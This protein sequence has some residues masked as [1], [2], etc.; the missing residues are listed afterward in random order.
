MNFSSS[1]N[2][3]THKKQI[4]RNV[5]PY[6]CGECSK[7]FY[8]ASALQSHQ[9]VHTEN[10]P[11]TCVQCNQ[12][13]KCEQSLNQHQRTHTGEK[14]YLCEECNTGF[15]VPASL[16]RHKESFHTKEGMNLHKRQEYRVREFLE[17]FDFILDEE[18]YIRYQ[19]SCVENPD[20]YS[21][22]CRLSYC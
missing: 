9:L 3:A 20:R 4:H 22:A 19:Q 18:I 7:T 6:L 2:F 17:E 15:T 13:F 14:P 5:R 8:R 10:R 21:L 16:R 11:F 1:S 12:A